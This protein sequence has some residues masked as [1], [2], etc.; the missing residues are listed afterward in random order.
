MSLPAANLVNVSYSDANTLTAD[1]AP[2]T[3][4]LVAGY[5]TIFPQAA[6]Y[7]PVLK[8]QLGVVVL[9]GTPV[10]QTVTAD[11]V[12]NPSSRTV[13]AGDICEMN[14]LLTTTIRTVDGVQYART[15]AGVAAAFAVGSGEVYVPPGGDITWDA[16]GIVYTGDDLHLN[17][18]PSV[19]L[20]MP[21]GAVNVT[22]I[23]FHGGGGGTA[24][25]L[26]VDSGEG[27]PYVTLSAGNYTAM[28]PALGD[29]VYISQT[30]NDA[31]VPY[32]DIHVA[33]VTSL[34][35]TNH[36]IY[37]SVPVPKSYTVAKSATIAKL[38][39]GKRNRVTG[40]RV[41]GNGN[42]GTGVGFLYYYEENFS[43]DNLRGDS[44]PGSFLQQA[45]PCYGTRH[46]YVR[47][48][49]CGPSNDGVGVALAGC[50]GDAMHGGFDV[51][52]CGWGTIIDGA[53]ASDFTRLHGKGNTSRNVKL[54]NFKK[55][56]VRGII[57]IA[58]V[59]HSGFTVSGESYKNTFDQIE[60]Q[61]N[62]EPG[63]LITGQGTGNTVHDNNYTNVFGY[64]NNLS[65]TEVNIQC[66]STMTPNNHFLSGEWGGPS[67][68]IDLDGGNSFSHNCV[69][70][71]AHNAS[72]YGA[73]SGT[74]GSITA[75]TE[76]NC[77]WSQQGKDMHFHGL[78]FNSSVSAT[79]TY[80]QV[81]LPNGKTC[82]VNAVGAAS[83]REAGN[84]FPAFC[85][86]IAGEA[87]IRIY[88]IGLANFATTVDQTDVSYEIALEV[89]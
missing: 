54:M 58:S 85:R 76:E 50:F 51:E 56:N 45:S 75:I 64:L 41:S 43:Y 44:L 48:E 27:T 87:F 1:Q 19:Q 39:C 62:Y 79:P 17:W 46:G 36:A 84:L 40:L 74:W 73:A 80:L 88:K 4:P 72:F 8:S 42:T 2:G 67:K 35:A 25:A 89:Q 15:R 23:S 52:A 55:N 30:P 49:R 7:N 11:V 69:F 5:A 9:L 61:S 68:V 28:A 29:I 63:V 32:S 37:L 13:V 10:G 47:A 31:A 86:A 78:V 16:T 22:P 83:V 81:T 34:D 71:R 14:S 38:S 18:H 33:R 20:L 70:N 57:G 6:M 53:C 26:S 3:A 59:T 12:S 66:N 65:G 82:A 77:N 60:V 24:Y 21:A